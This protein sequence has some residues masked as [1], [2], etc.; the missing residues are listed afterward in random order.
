MDCRT[1][2]SMCS[3][4]GRVWEVSQC[5]QTSWGCHE[6]LDRDKGAQRYEL[7]W[8]GEGTRSTQ[9]GGFEEFK[10]KMAK[11]WK[12]ESCERKETEMHETDSQS[13]DE[14]VGRA[15]AERIDAGDDASGVHSDAAAAAAAA[16]TKAQQLSGAANSSGFATPPSSSAKKPKLQRAK[17]SGNLSAALDDASSVGGCE[18]EG[19]SSVDMRR[20]PP[21]EVAESWV[22]RT[23]LQAC[24]D[25]EKK[26]VQIHHAEKAARSLEA[27]HALRLK[28]HLRM[29]ASAVMLSEKEVMSLSIE[30]IQNA[31]KD[32]ESARLIWPAKLQ[33]AMVRKCIE[34]QVQSLGLAMEPHIIEC[35]YVMCRPFADA[36]DAGKSFDFSRPAVSGCALDLSSKNRFFL[37]VMVGDILVPRV[38]H[39]S[40]F[41]TWVME[42]AKCVQQMIDKDLEMDLQESTVKVLSEMLD[43]VQALQLLVCKDVTRKVAGSKFIEKLMAQRTL[44]G[45]VAN[46]ASAIQQT[47]SYQALCDEYWKDIRA[48]EV[49]R[50]EMLKIESLLEEPWD[51]KSGCLEA[52]IEVLLLLTALKSD[53][54][55]D[56]LSWPLATIA[57]ARVEEAWTIFAEKAKCDQDFEEHFSVKVLQKLLQEATL[58]WPNHSCYADYLLQM[59]SWITKKDGKDRISDFMESFSLA[60][61]KLAEEQ[62]MECVMDAKG[63]LNKCEGLTLS[64]PQVKSIKDGFQR[65]GNQLLALLQKQ[66]QLSTELMEVLG[67]VK[68]YDLG[69]ELKSEW[70]VMDD[71]L[72]LQHAMGAFVGEHSTVAKMLEHDDQKAKLLVVCNKLKKAKEH[73]LEGCGRSFRGQLVSK[74]EELVEKCKT[75]CLETAASEMLAAKLALDQ[76]KNGVNPQVHWAAE[77]KDEKNWDRRSTSCRQTPKH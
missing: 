12:N 48:L 22:K 42:F 55:D 1:T 59:A 2:M 49:H 15:S 57:A 20:L 70:Q 30:E 77:L 29:V 52:M 65:A 56:V 69:D 25:G 40:G 61:K 24:L 14:E 46:L 43:A 6:E 74:T 45:P 17:S 41:Q 34:K 16:A 11:R 53:L 35:I 33:E 31:M 62:A 21:E 26:G 28:T 32:L 39:G 76:Y 50:A 68:V 3:R 13:S 44:T 67:L 27:Q 9:G 8:K 64:E 72:K 47:G 38:L 37:Q 60:V 36:G 71:T 73:K 63:K 19:A 18:D 4:H 54:P 10:A 75:E 7:N 51:A 58:L 5:T 66:P 23:P